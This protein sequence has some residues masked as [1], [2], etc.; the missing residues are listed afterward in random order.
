MG[1]AA[2]TSEKYKK[3]V[4]SFRLE[5][6]NCGRASK[7]AGVT[8]HT[9]KQAWETGWPRKTWA[10][11][12]KQSFADEVEA[13]RATRMRL[14]EEAEE[15]AET[16]R[17][18]ARQDAIEARAQE[19]RGAKVSRQ[20]AINLGVVSARLIMVA[21]HMAKEMEARVTGTDGGVGIKAMS[22][23]ELRKWML[24]TGQFT[25]MAQQT[26]LWALQ[27]ERL[28]LG[29][30]LAT[31]GVRVENME[32]EQLLKELQGINRTLMRAEK[33]GMPTLRV[34]PNPGDHMPTPA[35]TTP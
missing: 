9:A 28:V 20:N 11:S 29:E 6:G 21:D 30:P 10:P 4:E 27:I 8:W 25:R 7:F 35:P 16:Q 34:M 32:P 22:L 13:A 14:Q 26:M 1:R 24:T 18:Q 15:R 17:I 5:P 12:I 19:G 23:A 33:L 3:L 31:V 2:L